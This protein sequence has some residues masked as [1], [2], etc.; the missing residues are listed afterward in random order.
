MKSG[1]EQANAKMMVSW[2]VLKETL[3][4]VWVYQDSGQFDLVPSLVGN[5]T[6]DPSEGQND[7][8][9]IG[10]LKRIS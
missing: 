4:I 6:F 1:R 2:S 5:I 8:V 3:L 7:E 10:L 9:R